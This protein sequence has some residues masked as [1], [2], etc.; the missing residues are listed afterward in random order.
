M[1]G[2]GGGGGG[3]VVEGGQRQGQGEWKQ[4]GEGGG[5]GARKEVDLLDNPRIG[6]CTTHATLASSKSSNSVQHF[7]QF[8]LVRLRWLDVM[9]N[10]R[11]GLFAWHTCQKTANLGG[12][13]FIIA[14]SEEYAT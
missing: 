10:W 9:R 11:G 4:F 3:G 5:G 2:G 6:H 12:R 1:E 8:G 7:G 14:A 13:E